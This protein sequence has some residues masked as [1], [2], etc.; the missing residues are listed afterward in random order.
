MFKGYKV[1]R[2]KVVRGGKVLLGYYFLGGGC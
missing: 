1:I 2:V